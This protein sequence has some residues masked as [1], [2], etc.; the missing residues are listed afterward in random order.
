MEAPLEQTGDCCS[1]KAKSKTWKL[2]SCRRNSF[3]NNDHY[4]LKS[5]HCFCCF[6]GRCSIV[7]ESGVRKLFIEKLEAVAL[8]KP[9]LKHGSFLLVEGIHLVIMLITIQNPGM[10]F[11]F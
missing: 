1:T 10:F 7:T 8:L 3:S 4:N 6:G 2:F 9:N 11:P 5:R